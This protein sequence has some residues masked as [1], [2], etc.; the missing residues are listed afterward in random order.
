MKIPGSTY[1]YKPLN[2]GK[3]KG[4][5]VSTSTM[6]RDNTWVS[7]EK[8]VS[9]ILKILRFDRVYFYNK[10]IFSIMPIEFVPKQI[11]SGI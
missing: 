6:R 9:H 1:Y 10:L 5:Q 4:R 8:V 7:N 3:T 11:R 2:N